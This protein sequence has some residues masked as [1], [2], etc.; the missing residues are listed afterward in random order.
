MTFKSFKSKWRTLKKNL[1]QVEEEL[2]YDI[3]G[4][5]K[6]YGRRIYFG[7]GKE[8]NPRFYTHWFAQGRCHQNVILPCFMLNKGKVHGR[9]K[10]ITNDLHSAILDTK[11][12]AAY[13]PT[14]NDY[15]T[16]NNFFKDGYEIQELFEHMPTS[17]GDKEK[18][19]EFIERYK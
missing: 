8:D 6:F 5:D 7:C 10:V 15:K 18:L 1:T 13:C 2:F 19:K 4:I 12:N 3:V 9:Y 14:L 17:C 11:T 16:F